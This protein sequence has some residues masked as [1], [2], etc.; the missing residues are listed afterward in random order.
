MFL[1]FAFFFEGIIGLSGARI[2]GLDTF[3]PLVLI[4]VGIGVVAYGLIRSRGGT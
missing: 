3:L 4:V 2:P 1:A